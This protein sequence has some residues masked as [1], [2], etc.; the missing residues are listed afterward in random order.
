MIGGRNVSIEKPSVF[1]KKHHGLVGY[2]PCSVMVFTLAQER[3]CGI[4]YPVIRYTP[5]NISAE[6]PAPICL[7]REVNIQLVIYLL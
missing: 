4:R 6:R 3:P 5:A 1:R 7:R 2:D